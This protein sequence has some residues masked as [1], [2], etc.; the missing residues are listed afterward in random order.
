MATGLGIEPPKESVLR[1]VSSKRGIGFP[2]RAEQ[3]EKLDEM[4]RKLAFT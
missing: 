1:G 3:N 4:G 2:I